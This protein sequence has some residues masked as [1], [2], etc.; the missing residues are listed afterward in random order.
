MKT[1]QHTESRNKSWLFPMAILV[2]ATGLLSGTF[3]TG[4][5]YPFTVSACNF[6]A[7]CAKQ[8]IT[9]TVAGGGSTFIPLVVK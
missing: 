2:S 6:V 4:G 3:T 8:Q 5:S 1:A 7:P 9:L